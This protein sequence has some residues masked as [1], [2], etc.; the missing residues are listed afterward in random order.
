MDNVDRA[1]AASDYM[2]GIAYALKHASE[3]MSSHLLACEM[4][5]DALNQNT[6]SLIQFDRA[7]CN[8]Q[9]GVERVLPCNRKEIAA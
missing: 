1:F 7:I 8:D 5:R 3:Q 4:R 9:R 2:A 6:R